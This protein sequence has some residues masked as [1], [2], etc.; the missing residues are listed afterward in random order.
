VV[1]VEFDQSH[2][3]ATV[4]MRPNHS[5]TWRA[6]RLLLL[7]LMVVSG[8]VAAAFTLNGL[9]LILPFTALEMLVLL[10][11]L[12]YCVRRARRQEVIT[13]TADEV[14]L[15]QGHDRPEQEFTYPRFFARFRVD[16]PPHPW[17]SMRVALESR[18]NQHEIGAFLS[19]AE[20]RELV[21]DLRELL[22]RLE[23]P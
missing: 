13:M 4:V 9:W 7:T 22:H 1:A 6:N 12:A 3:V 2:R 8:S 5:W 20:K 16:A 14:R 17:Y 21:R 23:R 10:G 15:Q 19:D 18:G 11:C